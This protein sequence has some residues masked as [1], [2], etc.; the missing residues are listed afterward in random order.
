MSTT[1][2]VCPE[3]IW[4][5]LVSRPREVKKKMQATIHENSADIGLKMI[6]KF[7]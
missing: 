3:L 5:E 6:S 2:S 7:V 1:T 4:D